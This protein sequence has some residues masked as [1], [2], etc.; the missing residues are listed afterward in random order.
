MNPKRNQLTGVALDDYS[1]FIDQRM[2]NLPESGANGLVE[3]MKAIDV[4]YQGKRL[5][6]A[7]ATYN[8][9]GKAGVN[10]GGKVMAVVIP[11][12]TAGTGYVTG[13]EA[14]ITGDGTGALAEVVASDGSGELGTIVVSAG[15]TGY[16]VW[17]RVEIAGDGFGAMAQITNVD[18]VTGEIT[19]ITMVKH[20]SGYTTATATINTQ[21]GSGATFTTFLPTVGQCYDARVT[22]NGKDY[23]TATVDLTVSGNGDAVGTATVGF[24]YQDVI[25]A[26]NA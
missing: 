2:K 19:G 18:A 14:L 3:W 13:D 24:S 26:I 12:V 25:D 11:T 9:V 17:D 10:N 1:L 15:G 21:T 6:Q 4:G 20:G 5:E 8:L 16:K 7:L 22:M 23:T